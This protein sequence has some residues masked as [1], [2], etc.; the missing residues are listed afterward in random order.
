[1]RLVGILAGFLVGLLTPLLGKQTA[2][3]CAHVIGVH[4]CSQHQGFC[5][6]CYKC[7]IDFARHLGQECTDCGLFLANAQNTDV[8]LHDQISYPGRKK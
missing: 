8:Y 5:H 7:Q 2:D 1:M 3:R 4:H 6:K